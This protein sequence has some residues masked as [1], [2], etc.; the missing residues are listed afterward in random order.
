MDLLV[1]YPRKVEQ[2]APGSVIFE[3]D[4]DHDKVSPHS[5]KHLDK[6]RLLQLALP[7][8]LAHH[9]GRYSTALH[10]TCV[11]VCIPSLPAC[12]PACQPACLPNTALAAGGLVCAVWRVA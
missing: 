8:L 5:H 11:Y 7:L 10:S 1:N 6:Y 3:V 4:A 9:K 2:R 12:L